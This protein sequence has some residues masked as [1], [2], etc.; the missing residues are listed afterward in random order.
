MHLGQRV[1]LLVA[2]PFSLVMCL[3]L[4]FT[5]KVWLLLLLRTAQGL[6]QGVIGAASSNYI[7]EVSESHLR[8]RLMGFTV[9]G[10]KS[11]I[12]L[13]Y[14]IGSLDMSWRHIILVCGCV[15][16]IPP[17][18]GLF[19]LPNSPRWLVTRGRLEEARKALVFFRGPRYDSQ[20]EFDDIVHQFN[21]TTSNNTSFVSQLRQ[22]REQSVLRRLLFLI[23]LLVLVQFTGMVSILTYVVP[24]F[25]AS[26]SRINSYTSA[27]FVGSIQVAGTIVCLLVVD[28]LGRKYTI[29]VPSV[30]CSMSMMTLGVYFYLLNQGV[31]V[32]NIGWLP[33][34]AIMIFTAL[35]SAV[36]LSVSLLR[37]ELLPNSLRAF[38]TSIL[39]IFLY[40]SLFV[41]I[42]TF[43]L[44]VKT[45]GED[46]VFWIYS[47]CSL[48][49]V[50]GVAI[51]LQE[52]RGLSLEEIDN[53]FR[54][55]RK[56]LMQQ[57]DLNLPSQN[58]P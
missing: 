12:L 16:A 49:L 25:Q 4:S 35:F 23:F 21:E 26:N 34:A 7:A 48:L 15:T 1:S 13:V 27:I 9:V 54:H 50:L 6:T 3:A 8:G 40:A 10:W 57:N 29:I 41:V 36:D 55:G 56:H 51:F 17:F 46:G 19:F 24:I 47:V 37:A 38:A 30:I 18:I 53:L 39:Y 33:L 58:I 52:T 20:P 2:M 22:T 28:R 45:F 44:M 14:I 31:D 11:G 5:P 32:S 43:P 42:Q